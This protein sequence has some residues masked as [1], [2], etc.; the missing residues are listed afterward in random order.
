MSTE[1][2]HSSLPSSQSSRQTGPHNLKKS[3][4]SC[5]FLS[6]EQI[7]GQCHVVV[8]R[9]VRDL[10]FLELQATDRCSF[11]GW[12]TTDVVLTLLQQKSC[13]WTATLINCLLPKYRDSSP[14]EQLSFNC[15]VWHLCGLSKLVSPLE[16]ANC[17][18]PVDL[19]SAL[20]FIPVHI[21]S[22]SS[23]SALWNWTHAWNPLLWLTIVHLLAYTYSLSCSLL[24]L[25]LKVSCNKEQH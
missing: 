24:A 10:L 16:W 11:M 8:P 20:S 2:L 1:I 13:S 14:W 6:I 12:Y 25:L 23:L 4:S 7:H 15:C 21:N 9:V 19:T 5:S 17:L 3:A 18:E 22:L